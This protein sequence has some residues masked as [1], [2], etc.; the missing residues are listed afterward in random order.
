M[1]AALPLSGQDPPGEGRPCPVDALRAFPVYP[2]RAQ[3]AARPCCSQTRP[4]PPGTDQDRDEAEARA[5]ALV[6]IENQLAAV[7]LDEPHAGCINPLPP[8]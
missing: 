5:A 3:H 2:N 1:Q 4:S 6:H 7:M 8:R